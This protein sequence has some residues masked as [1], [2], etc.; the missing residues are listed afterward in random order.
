MSAI[1]QSDG[2]AAASSSHHRKKTVR[3]TL[4]KA[5]ALDACATLALQTAGLVDV[6]ANREE[7][8]PTNPLDA[9]G[10]ARFSAAFEGFDVHAAV[11]VEANDDD[12]RERLVRYCARP[13]L[14]LD[15]LSLS[16]D[17][18]VAT[19]SNTPAGRRRPA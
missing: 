5:T 10:P 4:R 1:A 19:G 7:A 16:R 9:R 11:R 15:R 2:C 3:T 14:A 17:G 12:A 6:S 13:A 8:R 18:A